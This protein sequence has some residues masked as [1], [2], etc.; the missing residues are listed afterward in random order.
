MGAVTRAAE[1]FDRRAFTVSEVVRNQEAGLYAR[2]KLP[3][4]CV[5]AAPNRRTYPFAGPR[6]KSWRRRTERGAGE[7]LTPAALPGFSIR[8]SDH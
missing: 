3:E 4:C 1:G 5:I 8:L 2:H 7:V 6:A